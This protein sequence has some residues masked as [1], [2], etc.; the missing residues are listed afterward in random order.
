MKRLL[1]LLLP[2]LLLSQNNYSLHFD[3]GDYLRA[4]IANYRSSDQRGSFVL[5]FKTDDTTPGSNYNIISSSD[6]ATTVYS[7]NF[8]V[9]SPTGFTRSGYRNNAVLDN[10][11]GDIQV[12][13]GWGLLYFASNGSNAILSVD[14]V[15]ATTSVDQ[16]SDNGNWFADNSTL[17]DNLVIGALVRTSA[18]G[19]T[20]GFIDEVAYFSD[21]LTVAE[22][23]NIYNGGTPKDIS[24]MDHLEDYFRFEEGTG[25]TTQNEDSD[26]TFIFGDGATGTTY[27]TWSTDTP[28]WDSGGK[29]FKGYKGWKGFKGW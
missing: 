5:W 23:T 6:E 9:M 21:T 25:T 16:G 14:N 28:G 17:R 29:G 26:I 10:I 2:C 15:F 13:S 22:L 4:L 27:P 18:V 11:D 24:G 20:Q 3:G 8:L 1:F 7:L 12:P 19:F